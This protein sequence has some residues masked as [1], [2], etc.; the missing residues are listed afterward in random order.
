MSY[1]IIHERKKCIGCGSCAAICPENWFMDDDGKASVKRKE[2][3]NLGCNELAA[4]ACPA[5]IIKIQ[6]KKK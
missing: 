2:I 6:K 3:E 1:R 4:K 5:Q